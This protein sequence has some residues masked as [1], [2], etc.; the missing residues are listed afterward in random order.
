M[1]KFKHIRLDPKEGG[2]A[3]GIRLCEGH[4]GAEWLQIWR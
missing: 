1:A 3:F 4:L 2:G